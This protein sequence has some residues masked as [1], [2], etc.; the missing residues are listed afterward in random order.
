MY[1]PRPG[2]ESSSL[3]VFPFYMYFTSSRSNS[4]LD[5]VGVWRLRGR[6]FYPS[7]HLRPR[8]TVLRFVCRL[9]PQLTSSFI[10]LS[11]FSTLDLTTQHILVELYELDDVGDWKT[12]IYTDDEVKAKG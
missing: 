4:T 1:R 3:V 10:L 6:S 11:I 5:V 2:L 8:D 12:L 9:G 7:E